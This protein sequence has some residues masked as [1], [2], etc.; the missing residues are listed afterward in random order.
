MNSLKI[1]HI[2]EQ[3]QDIIIVPLDETFGYRPLDERKAT[4]QGIQA[5]AREQGIA[6]TVVPV[7][8]KDNA[9]KFIAP[10]PWHPFFQKVTWDWLIGNLNRELAI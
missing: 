6:G 7:W 8:P 2:S 1:A 5:A 3:G 4:L 9:M 10:K